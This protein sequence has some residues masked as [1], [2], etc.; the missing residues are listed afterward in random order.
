MRGRC[1][2]PCAPKNKFYSVPVREAVENN[3]VVKYYILLPSTEVSKVQFISSWSSFQTGCHHSPPLPTLWLSQQP[4]PQEPQISLNTSTRSSCSSATALLQRAKLAKHECQ[5]TGGKNCI[6]M[7]HSN[8]KQAGTGSRKS[9]EETKPQNFCKSMF[10]RALEATKS[11]HAF[12]RKVLFLLC[13]EVSLGSTIFRGVI[14]WMTPSEK[15]LGKPRSTSYYNHLTNASWVC[16]FK[17]K[18]IQS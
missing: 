7:K 4:N 17:S 9:G 14:S 12:A 5:T 13:P 8:R 10:L 1:F 11:S 16:K 2:T 6:E 15:W 18:Q 3:Q